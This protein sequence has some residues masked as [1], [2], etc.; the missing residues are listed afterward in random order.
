MKKRLAILLAVI[1]IITSVISNYSMVYAG[2]EDNPSMSTSK[3]ISDV[4]LN[5]ALDEEGYYPA[6][7]EKALFNMSIVVNKTDGTKESL[8]YW[9]YSDWDKKYCTS[10]YYTYTLHFYNANNE[11]VFITN[12][13]VPIGEY[14]VK[15]GWEYTND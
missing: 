15:V 14:K 6:S 10:S 9:S 8:K 13:S 12:T 5:S 1:L 2:G 4:V 7:V 3:D 11:E